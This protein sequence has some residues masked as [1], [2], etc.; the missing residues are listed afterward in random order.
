MLLLG[1]RGPLGLFGRQVRLDGEEG[2]TAVRPSASSTPFLLLTTICAPCHKHFTV[3]MRLLPTVHVFS[4]HSTFGM[5][6]SL[7]FP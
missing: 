1:S 5:C 2:G 6:G 7:W 3:Y 4:T